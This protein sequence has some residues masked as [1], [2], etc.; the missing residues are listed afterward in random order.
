MYLVCQ[1]DGQP[2]TAGG[3]RAA[4]GEHMRECFAKKAI[5]QRFTFQD[6]RAKSGSDSRDGRLLGHF[7]KRTLQRVYRRKPEHVDPVR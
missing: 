1:P 5:E 2:Y 7:D 4:F 6:L 3:F